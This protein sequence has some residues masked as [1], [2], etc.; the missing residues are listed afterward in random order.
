ME[1]K[2]HERSYWGLALALVITELENSGDREGREFCITW[3]SALW[4][5]S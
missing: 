4:R 2:G 1:W 5:G 3:S